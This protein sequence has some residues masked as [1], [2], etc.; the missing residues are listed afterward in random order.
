MT[1]SDLKRKESESLDNYL[2]RLG[3]NKDLYSINWQQVA[4]YMNAEATEDF[5]ESKW[6]K[7]YA[8]IKRGYDLAV[9]SNVSEDEVLQELE[10]KTLEFRKERMK[11]Q[12]VRLEPNQNLRL[13][14][15]DELIEEKIINAIANRPLITVPDFYIKSNNVKSDYI[16][17]VADIHYA[18]N[19]KLLGWMDEI[20]NEYNPEIA[21]KRMWDLLEQ[22][23]EQNDI[24]KIN[25]A[26]L[27][28]LGDSLD[29]ILRMSQLQW[30]KMGNVD[31]AI[32]FAEFMSSWLNELSK[33]SALD[34]YS[35]SGNHT[36]LRLLNGKRGDFSAENMEKVVS[37]II[38][39]NLKNNNNVTVHKC[40]NHKYVDI[41]GT[42]VLAVHG[43]DERNLSASLNEYP[44][45]YGHPVDLMLSGHLH[46][47]DSKTIGMN[48][49]KDIEYIQLQSVVGIDDFSLKIKKTANAGAKLMVIKEGIGRVTTHD[50]RVN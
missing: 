27:F 2:L 6:R 40:R 35:V 23:V 24:D 47:T 15:R 26:H 9:K 38:E 30:I 39:C 5:S 11:L 31:S 29:G 17:G 37:Y 48:G 7:D 19:F 43:H 14:A 44:K 21:Q 50:F 13:E 4:D 1:P 10:D 46:H 22:Y 8:L 20:L 33:Y 25:H 42:K 16:F 36:E 45:I 12:S 18:A 32:E 49:L 28:N 3:N 34:Y 41:L